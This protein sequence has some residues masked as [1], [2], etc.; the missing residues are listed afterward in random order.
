MGRC[1]IELSYDGTS[2]S[3]W[4]IQDNACTVQEKLN[5]ELSML[6]D[7]LVNTTG[8]GRTDKGVHASHFYAHF[9][10]N[11]N[12]PDLKKLTYQLNAILP[13]DIAVK[14]IFTVPSKSHARYD[15][16]SRTY[17]YYIHRSKNPF[18]N[19]YS[20]FYSKDIN[21][22]VLNSI[23]K[24]LIGEMSFKA[25]SKTNTQVNNYIC[26]IT[27]AI[28]STTGDRLMFKISANRFLR[29]MVRALVGTLLDM[30]AKNIPVNTI[31]DVINSEE[32]K[33]AGPSV[34]AHGLFLTKVEYPFI[35]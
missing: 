3:G 34:A 30:T 28:W 22:D 19:K 18:L 8:C 4:Q 35:E 32:R 26:N 25:F 23:S 17:H 24:K 9:D 15:A 21:M 12:D 2:Y 29:G 13:S 33:N 1:F 27:E 5:Q 14:K 6:L 20:L 31:T 10:I 11:K 7:E 16:T